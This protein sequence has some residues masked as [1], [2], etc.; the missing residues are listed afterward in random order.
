MVTK[1]L[2]FDKV[3]VVGVL[4][5]SLMLSIPDFRAYERAFSMLEQVAGRAGRRHTQGHVVLQT[6]DTDAEVIQQVVN[7]DYLGMYE[8]QLAERKAFLYPPYC[9]IIYIYLKHRDESIIEQLSAHV[10]SLLHRQFGE[11]LM[12]PYTPYVSWVQG[13]H[14]RQLLLKIE[15][16]YSTNAV[17]QFLRLVQQ[18][19]LSRILFAQARF[20]Y[21]VD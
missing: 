10:A 21:D 5:A 18:Q 9:R 12:G 15:L 17:R 4:N 3:S 2:D 11:R 16:R 14:I 7:H 20:Y 19:V 1:G 6:M 8:S 13:M